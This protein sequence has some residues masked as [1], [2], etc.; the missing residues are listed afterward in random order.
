MTPTRSAIDS[1][2]SWSWVTNTVVTP[3]SSWMRR[4]SSRSCS[5]TL[6]SSADSGSS[7]SRTR[8]LDGERA[9]ERDPLLLAA[10]HLVRVLLGVLRR[11]PTRS[12]SSVARLRR[13][14]P[15]LLAHPQPEGDVV[16][17]RHGR[18]QAVGL[19]DHAHVALVRRGAGDVLA[20]DEQRAG[21]RLVEPGQQPQR[22]RLAAAR[23][24]EQGHAARRVRWSGRD[25]R[26]RRSSPNTRR[27]PAVLDRRAR[28]APPAARR[29]GARPG[30]GWS[31][32][33]IRFFSPVRCASSAHRSTTRSL[34]RAAG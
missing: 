9:G 32:A 27:D 5:R 28:A 3:S 31:S 25:R 17:G 30:R 22:R 2:S 34:R 21:R 10:G 4:I 7:S 14:P 26:G 1:A 18:E 11:D 20:V 29:S 23:R 12:S 6:A 24:P 15:A 8:G 16:G 33:T 19:E 13:A